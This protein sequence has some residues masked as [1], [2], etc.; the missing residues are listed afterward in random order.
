MGGTIELLLRL[1][2]SMAVVMAV[3]GVAARLVRR[4]Q[5]ALPS[6]GTARPAASPRAS[7][8]GGVLGGTGKSRR[9]RPAPAVEVVYRR[10]LAKGAAVAVVQ[11]TGKQFLLGVTEQSVTLL[12]ELPRAGTVTALEVGGPGQAHLG[13]TSVDST[14]LTELED[15]QQAGRMPASP[16]DAPS[17]ERQNAWKLTLDSLR[18]RTVRR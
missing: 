12:A 4:R 5:E 13:A 17:L 6:L 18:E 3:M 14:Q 8:L 9:P 1:A 7:M 15:W 2:I 11:A 10:S 16:T